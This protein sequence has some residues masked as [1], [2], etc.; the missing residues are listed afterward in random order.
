MLGSKNV[1]EVSRTSGQGQGM[2]GSMGMECRF[3]QH[4]LY[5][6]IKSSNKRRKEEKGRGGY[7]HD[8]Q[9]GDFTSTFYRLKFHS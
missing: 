8:I 2:R 4:T 9:T 3:N 1:H 5:T 6:K 7:V